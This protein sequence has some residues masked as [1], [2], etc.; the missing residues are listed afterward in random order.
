MQN[1]VV[2]SFYNVNKKGVVNCKLYMY[3]PLSQMLFPN[4]KR[5]KEYLIKII[6]ILQIIIDEI[7]VIKMFVNLIFTGSLALIVKGLMKSK[8]GSYH[9][10]Q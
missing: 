2:I 4:F 8:D 6:Q 7:S 5:V 3:S 9:F 1:L 10:E